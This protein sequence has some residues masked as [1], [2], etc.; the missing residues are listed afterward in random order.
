[1]SYPVQ[2]YHPLVIDTSYMHDRV[3]N[4]SA[5]IDNLDEFEK[6]FGFSLYDFCVAVLSGNYVNIIKKITYSYQKDCVFIGFTGTYSELQVYK[7]IED[8]AT[9][10]GIQIFSDFDISDY[11][12]KD[13]NEISKL[14][15]DNFIG[16]QP[17]Q[18]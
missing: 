8:D 4:I 6:A 3:D 14:I 18:I 7:G 10:G 11:E 5:Q 16:A 12:T 9:Y 1:M 15:V 2:E 13:V 17:F